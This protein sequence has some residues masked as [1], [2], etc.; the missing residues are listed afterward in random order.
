MRFEY[1]GDGASL[2][3]A[4]VAAMVAARVEGM[5]DNG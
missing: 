5:L 1:H 3:S 2:M 4:S